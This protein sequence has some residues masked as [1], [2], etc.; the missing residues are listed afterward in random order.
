[1]IFVFL[2]AK[3]RNANISFKRKKLNHKDIPISVLL[4]TSAFIGQLGK[5]LD[6][7][8]LVLMHNVSFQFKN[9]VYPQILACT[10]KMGTQRVHVPSAEYWSGHAEYIKQTTSESFFLSQIRSRSLV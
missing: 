6:L 5:R 4:K 7:D 3:N 2:V 9:M 10:P 1:M 8:H